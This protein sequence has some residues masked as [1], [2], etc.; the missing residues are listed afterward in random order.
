[1]LGGHQRTFGNVGTADHARNRGGNFGVAEV[2]LG[3]AHGGFGGL[4]LGFGLLG[5]GFGIIQ[6]LLT[7]GRVFRQLF[8]TFSFQFGGVGVGF[9]DRQLSFGTGQSGFIEGGVNLVQLVTSSD[10]GA[11]FKE[12]LSNNTADLGADFC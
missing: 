1:M 6:F 11:F 4:Y 8:V 3:A 10:G 2:N 7:D 12:A 5:S 9:G